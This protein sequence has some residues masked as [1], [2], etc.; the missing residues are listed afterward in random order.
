MRRIGIFGGSF[1]PP[2]NG[3][4]LCAKAAANRLEIDK[5][6]VIPAAQQPLK[7]AGALASRS[8]RLKMLEATF[9]NDP[10][11]EISTIE[12]DRGGKSYTIDTIRALRSQFISSDV[13][14]YLIVGA[15]ALADIPN[16]KEPDEIFRHAIVA[17]MVRTGAVLPTFPATWKM[18][19]I[20]LDTPLID[21]SSREIRRRVA[22]GESINGLVPQEVERII[23]A[24]SL[25]IVQESTSSS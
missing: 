21:I 8:L 15:D 6:L 22:N 7:P 3:H 23:K 18:E 10:I 24:E 16:W 1:D 4:Y 20:H 25:Y 9:C 19:I 11:F 14:L 12:L 2:H 13:V 5:I 17:S